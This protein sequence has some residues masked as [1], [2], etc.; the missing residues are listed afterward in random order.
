MAS[1]GVKIYIFPLILTFVL[2]YLNV[3]LVSRV[4]VIP[5]NRK[6]SVVLPEIASSDKSTSMNIT[7]SP[8][9][10]T[11]EITQPADN[12]TK[13]CVLTATT[14]RLGH[15]SGDMPLP[16]YAIHSLLQTVEPD[17]VYILY[18]GYDS[19][20][21]YY[22]EL[23]RRLEL[24]ALAHPVPI[25]WIECKN[26]TRKPGPVFNNVSAQ[27][28]AEGCDYLY[29]INDDTEIQ[30]K[31]ASE[32]IKTLHS[33]RPSNIGVVGPTCYEGNTAILT[34]DF[35]HKTHHT[36][37]GFHYPP[38]LTDWWLDDWITLVYGKERT[39]K[40][41]NIKVIHHLQQTRYTVTFANKGKVLREVAEGA[42]AINQYINGQKDQ[43]KG[44]VVVDSQSTE[45]VWPATHSGLHPGLVIW[46]Q[47][48]NV[49][50]GTIP[51]PVFTTFGNPGYLDQ[52]KNLICNLRQFA[53]MHNHLLI[54]VTE[55]GMI[56]TLS[57][58]GYPI[59]IAVAPSAENGETS[60]YGTQ[61][62]NQL[63]LYRAQ[64]LLY[65]LGETEIVWFEA[66]AVYNQNL[67]E[68][69]E[70]VHTTSDITFFRDRLMYGG[71]FIRF[72]A[73]SAAK[74]FYE[75]VFKRLSDSVKNGQVDINDQT[76]LNQLLLEMPNLNF[77]VFD[78]CQ[79]RS[80]FFLRFPEEYT[81]C[82]Q[83]AVVQQ[84]NWVVGVPAK[85]A[86]AKAHG[87]WFL[88]ADNHSK[89]APRDL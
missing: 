63:M 73:T 54:I 53:G 37:F 36:I 75:E 69:P 35:V 26:P 66:D 14:S 28:V 48:K 58:L 34:H 45:Q 29:R 20:D 46:N 82:T 13:V 84:F 83:P 42:T 25:R 43:G 22:T 70:I 7:K 87:G 19:D 49:E 40:L 86:L 44:L 76:I 4:Q 33:F 3:S 1:W 56:D 57:K 39:R 9:H 81:N 30:G 89:C 65:I 64:T 62:Y 18:V 11:P 12:K 50:I 16:K 15:G 60:E 27:A 32:F 59:N 79:Y 67:L 72:A 74:S 80:G 10:V 78:K 77:T 38:I 71:G 21:V 31:W 51:R 41:D 5:T 61:L 85:L 24:D 52:L 47:G 68:R 88:T 2:V 17:F 23:E 55:R 8:N 6:P